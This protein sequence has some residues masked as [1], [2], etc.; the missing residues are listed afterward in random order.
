MI[1]RRAENTTPSAG[2]VSVLVHQRY[3]WRRSFFTPVCTNATIVALGVIASGG[4]LQCYAGGSCGSFPSV[5]ANVYCTDFSANTDY[6]LGERY[7]RYNLSL[8]T[9]YIIAFQGGAWLALQIGGNGNWQVTGKIDL[10][11][12]PDGI[13]NTSP[14]TSTLPVIYRT[15]NVQH[16]HIVQ[17]SDA[18]STD[19]LRCRWATNGTVTN[20]NNYNECGSVCSPSLPSF[21]LFPDNCTLVY[22]LLA[23]Q[24]YSSVALQIEDFYNSTTTTPMSTVPIQFLFYGV[25]TPTGCSTPPQII[26]AR[27][28]LGMILFKILL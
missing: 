19:T 26:G 14:V 6:S 8:N 3:A 16:V 2:K 10:T 11:V 4:T 18:D 27:P 20:P 12:R 22:T 9:Q 5:S 21:T 13:I 24:N 15:I 25:V 28:N 1:S 23:A 17:M 7:D